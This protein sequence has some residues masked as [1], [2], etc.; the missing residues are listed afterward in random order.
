MKEKII[1]MFKAGKSY[2][3]ISRATGRP[4]RSIQSMICYYRKNGHPELEKRS[5]T[6]GPRTVKE[7]PGATQVPEKVKL[8]QGGSDHSPVPQEPATT[9]VLVQAPE[10]TKTE[11]PCKDATLVQPCPSLDET[12]ILPQDLVQAPLDPA[13]IHS[14][15]DAALMMPS[16]KETL[17]HY[18][19]ELEATGR[20]IQSMAREIRQKISI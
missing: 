6:P 8:P 2:E 1:E 15:I 19:D 20:Y 7:G 9:K 18:A 14:L 11:A 4:I 3:E 17:K 16:L 5:S 10:P 12:P 13:A